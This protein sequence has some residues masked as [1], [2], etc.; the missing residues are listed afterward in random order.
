M[1]G[2]KLVSNSTSSDK[3]TYTA[4]LKPNIMDLMPNLVKYQRLEVAMTSNNSVDVE[5]SEVEKPP[6]LTQQKV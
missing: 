6:T 3:L 1:I 5:L 4:Y 2:Y